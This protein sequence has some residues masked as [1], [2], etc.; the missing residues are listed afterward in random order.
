MQSIIVRIGFRCHFLFDSRFF[1]SLRHAYTRDIYLYILNIHIYTRLGFV[2]RR[3]VCRLVLLSK[4]SRRERP[5]PPLRVRSPAVA[6]LYAQLS[7]SVYIMRA[8]LSNGFL[9][10][11]Q[12][13]IN[14]VQNSLIIV[15]IIAICD[16]ALY[17]IVPYTHTYIY[18]LYYIIV[19]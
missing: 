14:S 12:N 11:I 1:P 2:A 15:I 3:N 19:T 18:I 16:V 10:K 17:F 6:E 7:R 8:F 5:P 13:E 9:E 4:Y